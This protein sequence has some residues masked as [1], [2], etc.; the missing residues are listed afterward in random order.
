MIF[1]R[2]YF[3]FG[4]V[5][6]VAGPG[7][8]KSEKGDHSPV[9]LAATHLQRVPGLEAAEDID[10][11]LKAAADRYKAGDFDGAIQLASQI[12]ALPGQTWNKTALTLRAQ[13]YLD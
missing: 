2:R 5:T 6:L 10:T 4:I 13:S 7:W 11:L 1:W 9:A 3:I 8:A 12:L